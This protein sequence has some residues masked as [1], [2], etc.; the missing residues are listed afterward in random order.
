MKNRA[1][2]ENRLGAAFDLADSDEHHHIDLYEFI[3]LYFKVTTKTGIY[4]EGDIAQVTGMSNKGH[5]LSMRTVEY[6]ER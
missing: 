2:L 4:D 3:G 5:A 1:E 6:G